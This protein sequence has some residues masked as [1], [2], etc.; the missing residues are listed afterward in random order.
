MLQ[1]LVSDGQQ[2]T[3]HDALASHLYHFGFV[4]GWF[5]DLHIRVQGLSTS[6]R[7]SNGGSSS[8]APHDAKLEQSNQNQTS[9]FNNSFNSTQFQDGLLFKLHKII[10]I[11][12]PFLASLIQES[13][14]RRPS[15]NGS[16]PT[17]VILPVSDPNLTPEGLSIAFGHLYANYS[18]A[19][20][21]SL[22]S[23]EEPSACRS[24]SSILRSVLLAASLLQIRDLV[25]LSSDLIKKDMSSMS[26]SEYCRF[27]S[28]PAVL[29]ASLGDE[30][31]TN[32]TASLNGCMNDIR[33]AVYSFLC[34]GIVQDLVQKSA[35]PISWG[36]KESEGYS[37]L[38]SAF[39]E[40]PFEWMKRV[41]ESKDDFEVPS[42]MARFSFA[43]DVVALRA[44][45]KHQLPSLILAG[46][47]NVLLA[48][49]GGKSGGGGVTIVRKA[50]K[51][52]PPQQPLQRGSYHHNF[53]PD[54]G[55]SYSFNGSQAH[56]GQTDLLGLGQGLPFVSGSER[57]IWKAPS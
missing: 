49:G 47:E 20:L 33:D 53:A 39:S 45:R 32:A 19:I 50:P 3:P 46:E 42:D 18:H 52:E 57:K 44:K 35:S 24:R 22:V 1:D 38:V 36:S 6:S 17:E 21:S 8:S 37:S 10:A 23:S 13:E 7:L 5:S 48:F 26:I 2:N 16:G 41:I 43:K 25:S 34:R 30:D 11:R 29:P 28:Q 27:V 15:E 12:S 54:V 14:M 4:Q 31:A 51:K 9:L 40:L 56:Q 55:H